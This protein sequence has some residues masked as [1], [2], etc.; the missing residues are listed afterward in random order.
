MYRATAGVGGGTGERA[1]HGEECCSQKEEE[2]ECD[3]YRTTEKGPGCLENK[4]LSVP[5]KAAEV[6]GTRSQ[7]DLAGCCIC[8]LYS[9]KVLRGFKGRGKGTMENTG[10]RLHFNTVNPG[11]QLGTDVITIS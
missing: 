9:G 1:Q 3:L 11:G 4:E 2:R 5:N 10:P 6:S 7:Q 8:P